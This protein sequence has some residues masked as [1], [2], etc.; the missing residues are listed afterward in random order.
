MQRRTIVGDNEFE[1]IATMGPA[2]SDISVIER[3]ISAGVSGF[4]FP[5]AKET[6]QWQLDRAAA[7]RGVANSIGI[8]VQLMMDIPGSQPRLQTDTPLLVNIGDEILLVT[9]SLSPVTS[10]AIAVTV[11]GDPWFAYLQRGSILLTGDGDLAFEITAVSADRVSLK[12]LLSGIVP[13]RAKVT[14]LG[15]A[16]VSACLTVRDRELLAL[17]SQMTFDSIM[18]SFVNTAQDIHDVRGI[19]ARLL[20]TS[21]PKPSICAKIETSEAVAN[22]YS[23]VE[24]ADYVLVARGDLAMHTGLDFYAAQDTIINTSKRLHKPVYV[25]TQLLES[26]ASRW[27]PHRAELSDLSALLTEGISG[28]LL[29]AETTISSDPLRIVEVVKS[30]SLRYWRHT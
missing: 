2:I 10:A 28:I 27:I 11:T 5:F 24:A 8:S 26:A 6:P 22:I 12:A 9:R 23:I 18:V 20:P 4:R 19:L 7:V 13:Q 17:N 15:G 21:K 29:S 3:L 25:G 16:S 1:I 30:L 14:V